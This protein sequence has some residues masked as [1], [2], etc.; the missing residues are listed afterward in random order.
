MIA[1]FKCAVRFS[2]Q[3]NVLLLVPHLFQ[4]RCAPIATD[5]I[6]HPIFIEIKYAD[7]SQQ[8]NTVLTMQETIIFEATSAEE[9]MERVQ[10]LFTLN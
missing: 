4:I 8:D 5:I 6:G 10:A 3:T 1:R 7:C 2:S 9:S